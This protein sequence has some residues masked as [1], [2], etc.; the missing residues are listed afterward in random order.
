[1]A[2]SDSVI[3]KAD[4]P[5]PTLALRTV[6]DSDW[7][8][9]ALLGNTAFGEIGHP[10]S[11]SAW[12][13]MVPAD[14]A[15]VMRAGDDEDIVGQ[16]MYLDLALTVPGGA[17]LP[18]AGI[19]YVA[20]AP[21]HRRRGILRSMYTELHQRIAD[22]RYPVAALTAS[23]GG[24]Y[25]RF[26]YGP[27]TTVHLMTVDRRFAQFHAS[28]PDPGGV[29]LVKPAEH[30]DAFAEIY[31]RWRLR[32]PGGLA[33]P[34]ALWDDVLADRENTRDGGSE[35][36]AFLHPDG[37]ALYRV[38]GEE[39]RTLRVREV[40]AVTMDAYI[41]L[42]RAL[43]GMDLMEKVSTWTHPGDALPYLLTNPRLARVTSSSDD[44]W[45]RIM[46]VPAALEARRYQAD[47]DI[48]LDVT[49]GFR[50][51]GGRFAL[52]IRDGRARCTPTD[53]PADLELGLDVLGSLYLGSHHPESFVVANR[54]RGKDSEAVRRL[55]T[56][57]A[58]D[59]P[60]ELGYSF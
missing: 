57:F 43:L 21:T 16:S 19:S 37:Y 38:H 58:S 41:A 60:A 24:I 27:A 55:G 47:L 56:A 9:M 54:L 36:F 35:L 46:N 5:A 32:T 22:A 4:S 14:G 45:V 25:G 44:L 2:L 7:A 8:G 48:V 3:H 10:D 39:S 23:E 51:D 15:V 13:Q 28:V 59:V 29:R 20:V 30:R 1:M 42:W 18:A 50:D 40:T 26:G 6:T 49:D 12:Q 53:A 34:T 52:Q 17:V 33:C 11:M 31:D